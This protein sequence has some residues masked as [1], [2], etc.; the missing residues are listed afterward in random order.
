[1]EDELAVASTFLDVAKTTPQPQTRERHIGHAR[2]AYDTVTRLL[3]ESVQCS[4]VQR[5]DIQRELAKIKKRISEATRVT[6]SGHF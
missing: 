5:D 1:M 2:R 6:G 3:G 4:P